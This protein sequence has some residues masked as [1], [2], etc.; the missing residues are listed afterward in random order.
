VKCPICD[1]EMRIAEREGVEID[2]CQQC[3]GVWLDRGELE[4][5]IARVEQSQSACRSDSR[6]ADTLTHGGDEH[7][8]C[9]RTRAGSQSSERDHRSGEARRKGFLSQLLEAFG[10]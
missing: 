7:R 3:R 9:E 4:K 2:Y 6:A 1:L 8:D 10:D 5:I